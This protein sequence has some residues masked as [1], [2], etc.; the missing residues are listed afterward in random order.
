MSDDVIVTEPVLQWSLG[1]KVPSPPTTGQP[2][3]VV[4]SNSPCARD[5]RILAVQFTT[6]KQTVYTVIYSVMVTEMKLI[7]RS[8]VPSDNDLVVI[9]HSSLLHD[10]VSFSGSMLSVG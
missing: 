7:Y 3:K 9:R 6:G 4:Q 1:K 10:I 2:V 8:S 5:V